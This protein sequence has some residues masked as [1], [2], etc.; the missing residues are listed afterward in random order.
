M[1]DVSTRAFLFPGVL[2]CHSPSWELQGAVTEWG[3]LNMG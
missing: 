2:L 1:G 3:Y